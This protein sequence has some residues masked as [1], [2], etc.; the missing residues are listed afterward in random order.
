MS[1]TAG[2][3][4]AARIPEGF[5]RNGCAICERIARIDLS[6]VWKVDGST[7]FHFPGRSG[8]IIAVPAM[9][10]AEA[11]PGDHWG[12]D[13]STTTAWLAGYASGAAFDSGLRSYD[14]I[15][16]EESGHPCA[17]IVPLRRRG[18]P[19]PRFRRVRPRTR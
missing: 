5:A 1:E 7:A 3:L 14:L 2:Q 10:P 19:W 12:Y 4:A 18:L 11:D 6:G 13:R 16:T 9:H 17:E 8:R 15:I